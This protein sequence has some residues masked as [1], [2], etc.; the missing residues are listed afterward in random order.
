MGAGK[1]T[2]VREWVQR[3]APEVARQVVSP[4]FILH[5]RYDLPGGAV[6]HLDWYRLNSEAE[7]L[8]LGWEEIVSDPGLAIFVEWADKFPRLLPR[9]R[10]EVRFK[11]SADSRRRTV[12]M[13]N[14]GPR[15]SA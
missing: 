8:S 13:K 1:T 2:F 12:T 7:V 14:R 4:T 3:R 9:R 6:H 5:A 10:V 15:L 11:Y